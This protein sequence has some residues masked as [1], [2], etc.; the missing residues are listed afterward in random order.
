MGGFRLANTVR[1]FF[2]RLAE[3]DRIGV[4]PRGEDVAAS[5]KLAYPAG[6]HE[7]VWR[8][9]TEGFAGLREIDEHYSLSDLVIANMMLELRAWANYYELKRANPK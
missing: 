2:R 4:P 3:R 9:V 6:V 8:P 7:L 1:R 5:A